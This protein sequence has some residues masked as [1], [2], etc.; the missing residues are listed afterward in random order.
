MVFNRNQREFRIVVTRG[1]EEPLSIPISLDYKSWFLTYNIVL[2]KKISC[3]YSGGEKKENFATLFEMIAKLQ[4]KDD[5]I[6]EVIQNELDKFKTLWIA[7]VINEN[8]QDREQIKSIIQESLIEI[9]RIFNKDEVQNEPRKELKEELKKSIQGIQGQI[10]TLLNDYQQRMGDFRVWS[11]KLV[12]PTVRVD[13]KISWTLYGIF[14]TIASIFPC[15]ALIDKFG[16]NLFWLQYKWFPIIGTIIL[17]AL[18]M[19]WN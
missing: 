12:Q 18:S 7:S 15:Y 13:K 6:I 16:A 17:T 2:P 3:Y 1:E 19:A 10:S 5:R 14:L 4:N 8:K 11:E 9:T